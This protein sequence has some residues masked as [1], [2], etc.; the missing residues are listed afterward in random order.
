MVEVPEYGDQF[1]RIW[2]ELIRL[3]AEAT[4]PW[5]LIGSQMVH[6]RGWMA[7]ASRPSLSIEADVLANSVRVMTATEQLSEQL[8]SSGYEL[9]ENGALG[10]GIRFR[11]GDVEIDVLAPEKIS[12]RNRRTRAP[13][14]TVA[15]PGGRQALNRTIRVEVQTRGTSGEVPVPTLLGA[16]LIKARAI[17]VANRPESQRE[18]FAFLLSLI[19]DLATAEKY[20]EEL[21]GGQRG[22]LLEH[23]EIGNPDH[24]CWRRVPNANRGVVAYRRLIN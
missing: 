12:E 21:E 7:G 1:H 19:Q 18:D 13:F 5:T 16:I 24:P 17:G 2:D 23:S 4:V 8:V 10:T 3:A 9:T 22:W 14:R 15:V 11:R 6:M 20:K